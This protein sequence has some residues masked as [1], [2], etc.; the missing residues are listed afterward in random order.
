MPMPNKYK[1]FFQVAKVGKLLKCELQLG[2]D[3][4]HHYFY[5]IK[6]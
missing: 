6:G 2:K 1:V 5:I 3:A 4:I